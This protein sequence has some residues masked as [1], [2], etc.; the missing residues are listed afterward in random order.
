MGYSKKRSEFSIRDG[1]EA[2][3]TAFTG[4]LASMRTFV[5]AVG[6]AR[7]AAPILEMKPFHKGMLHGFSGMPLDGT[8]IMRKHFALAVVHGVGISEVKEV[9]YFSVQG[10]IFQ[11]RCHQFRSSRSV[12]FSSQVR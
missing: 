5:R 6:E 12:S 10:E 7:P 11:R 9:F 3:G 4:V 1:F 2:E 8:G